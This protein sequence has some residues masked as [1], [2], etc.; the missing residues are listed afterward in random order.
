MTSPQPKPL[1]ADPSEAFRMLHAMA[2]EAERRLDAAH[3]RLDRHGK[4]ISVHDQLPPLVERL[5]AQANERHAQI[6]Y[7]VGETERSI[8]AL[9]RDRKEFVAEFHE[10]IDK[11]RKEW[12]E[13]FSQLQVANQTQYLAIMER[14]TAISETLQQ[15]SHEHI[16]I[17]DDLETAKKEMKQVLE[18]VV[19]DNASPVNVFFAQLARVNSWALVTMVTTV[20][21]ATILVTILN[22]GA[23]W[24][25]Q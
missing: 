21:A 18:D 5:A 3:S 25:A 15:K 17:W 20:A 12:D 22:L 11:L 16:E 23:L 24:G 4:L 8:E 14:L 7:R 9:R 13:R 19:R 1:P 10:T 6:E 2:V